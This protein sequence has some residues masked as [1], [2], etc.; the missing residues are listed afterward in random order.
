[1]S[2]CYDSMKEGIKFKSPDHET[3]AKDLRDRIRGARLTIAEFRRRAGL[4]RNV[5]YSISKGRKA[6]AEE[7][8][9]IDQ[10][11]AP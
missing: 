8:K 9:R 3:R 11:L 2:S 7:Q 10:A 5:A 4:S 6:T 1:M